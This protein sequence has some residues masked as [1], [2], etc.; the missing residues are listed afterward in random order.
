MLPP[1]SFGQW[2][3]NR[4][5][6]LDLTQE[7]LADR[8]G[9]A[10]ETLRKVE[11]DRR[12]P[13]QQLVELLAEQLGISAAEREVFLFL[14]RSTGDEV[15]PPA[16]PS[17]KEQPLRA[18]SS[19]P[20]PLTPLIGRDEELRTLIELVQRPH[21]R[22][23]TLTGTG[24]TG[25]TRLALQLASAMR[26]VFEDG[27]FFVT[28]ASVSDPTLVI[29]SIARTLGIKEGGDEELVDNLKQFL[30][31][32]Q[33]LLILDNF[34][35]VAEAAPQLAE[36]VMAAPRLKLVTTSRET[37]RLYGE[38]EFAVGPLSLPTL[39]PLPA[40]P[41][42]EQCA[43]VT[44]F[45]QRAQAVRSSFALTAQN[46]RAVAELCVRLDG[47]PLA[48]EL[49][50]ARTKLF[51][52]AVLLNRLQSRL[53]LLT[54]GARNVEGRHQTLR[55]TI[56]WSYKLLTANEQ[57]LFDRLSV[58][59]G[60]STLQ[61]AEVVG[62]DGAV[63]QADVFNLLEQLVAKSLVVVEEQGHEPW[64]RMLESL[65]AYGAERLAE[66]GEQRACRL[67]HAQ[68]YLQLV[69]SAKSLGRKPQQI[70]LLDRLAVE[71]DN[72]RLALQWAVEQGEIELGMRMVSML[73]WLWTMH[74]Q[75]A[76]GLRLLD[77]VLAS[78]TELPLPVRAL[79][80]SSVSSLASNQHDFPL[81]A[82]A[83]ETSLQLWR[84]IQSP[85]GEAI[86]HL[87]AGRGLLKQQQ[88]S[89]AAEHCTASVK[90]FQAG[91]DRASSAVALSSL[92]PALVG[93]GDFAAAQQAATE[94]L[95]LSREYG[96]SWDVATAYFNLGLVACMEGRAEEAL[97]AYRSGLALYHT[98]PSLMDMSECLDGLDGYA[99]ALGDTVGAGLDA[100]EEAVRRRQVALIC[101]AVATHRAALDEI[102]S[103]PPDY[104]M[105]NPLLATRRTK[106]MAQLRAP[107]AG[108]WAAAAVAGQQLTLEQCVAV[109]VQGEPVGHGKWVDSAALQQG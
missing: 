5:K 27:L 88:W 68:Y 49:A 2:V 42:L 52:P 74:G 65:R 99:V 89:G 70:D 90:L 37:L 96:D 75:Y 9:C 81:A 100:T 61:A 78:E 106:V 56:D 71:Y 26:D 21:V 59:V 40:L 35:H 32:Q 67:R 31:A 84:T 12:R 39:H 8:V 53:D 20:T 11:A 28:L 10:P 93:K 47:L 30:Q 63:V 48:I 60:G 57:L 50:A 33:L 102:A 101:T 29:P 19:L 34:E 46:A 64:Y 91:G 7:A 25:K 55:A 3:K 69:E 108:D 85:V 54:D 76:E 44:L 107:S 16:P 104:Y 80:L 13:S 72:M 95:Q 73:A 58:F 22:L 38:Y 109:A 15:P 66:R 97:R 94:R 82:R 36:L 24:G 23:L 62:A 77:A 4:R 1:I 41:E 105:H 103:A 43:A 79:L 18:G 92:I 14:A 17:V 51:T 83:A 87:V 45:V 6:A 98:L 86:G